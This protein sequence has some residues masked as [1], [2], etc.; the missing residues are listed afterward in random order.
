MVSITAEKVQSR[1][2]II[3]ILFLA[4][5]AGL[6]IGASG[7]AMGV[8][9]NETIESP[10]DT[11]GDGNVEVRSSASPQGPSTVQVTVDIATQGNNT[12]FVFDADG[13]FSTATD[14]GINSSSSSVTVEDGGPNDVDGT[15]DGSVTADLIVDGGSVGFTEGDAFKLGITEGTSVTTSPDTTINSFSIDNT[16]PTI[17]AITTR[18]NG[19]ATG[20]VIAGSNTSASTAD[21]GQI[22]QLV[23]TFEEKIDDS[24]VQTGNFTVTGYTI[25]S[26][27]TAGT[28]NN[29]TIVIDL[30]E[31]G[32]ID[33]GATPEVNYTRGTLADEA[34]NP[35][36]DTVSNPTDGVGP[37]VIRSV[38][39]DANN[40]GTV[41]RVNVTFSENIS[42]STLATG[43][44]SLSGG[45]I[46]S[47]S[48]PDGND[49]AVANLTVSGLTADDTGLTPGLTVTKESVDDLTGNSG[50]AG[51]DQSV[52]S[53]DDAAAAIIS[54]T[55]NDTSGDGDIDQL[56]VIHSEAVDD[57]AST[58]DNTTYALSSGTVDSVLTGTSND[59]KTT[60]TV[61]G[62]SGTDVTPD[63]TLP[64]EKVL[65]DAGNTL[66]ADQT[67]TSTTSG[68]NPVVT[69]IT[70]L[71][72]DSD[73]NVDAANVTTS[74]AINDTT[75]TPGNWA[76]GDN[77]V[78]A[79]DTG[80]T[81]D[82]DALQLRITT[83]ANEATGT[84][85]KEV[86][87][88]PGTAEDV[89]GNSLVAIAAGDVS[90]IDGAPPQVSAFSTAVE[91]KNRIVTTINASES[92]SSIEVAVS[93]A[94]MTTLSSFSA[95]GS[96]PYTHTLTYSPGTTGEFTLTL[97]TAADGAGNDGGDSQTETATLASQS[98]SD[99][100]GSS[101]PS[102]PESLS[103]RVASSRTVIFS[104]AESATISLSGSSFSQ[105][106][107]R[108]TAAA[109][110]FIQASELSQLPSGTSQ[111][112]NQVGNAMSI[113]VPEDMRRN[114]ATVRLSLQTSQ[115]NVDADR[116]R[117]VR[118]NDETGAWTALD[119]QVVS[120]TQSTTLVRA[121]TPGFSLFALTAAEETGSDESTTE[122]PTDT[123]STDGK[124]TAEENLSDTPA[125]AP[126]NEGTSTEADSPGFAPVLTVMTLL[127]VAFLLGRKE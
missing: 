39:G 113:Q 61:S 35:L 40:D 73:G 98:S 93:G 17:N 7:T 47:V 6:V 36:D 100:S 48:N 124:D 96:D 116:L 64:A 123:T 65:D 109:T 92:L 37:R 53:V 16:A 20:T 85:A 81:A 122:S 62:L 105:I 118:Y 66:A 49:D 30:E 45:S 125:P 103:D 19:P 63:V 43:D 26:I 102:Y 58:L 107:I 13:D 110:G 126:N 34:G 4:V 23:V 69:A 11:D 41:D 33:T 91:D 50:P 99:S 57:A 29:D 60:I 8:A 10:A 15:T 111:P 52:T 18:D 78:D 112:P 2:I 77:S 31:S 87:Y 28:G 84:G 70:T 55:T 46:D 76:I 88:S 89:N 106:E 1:N 82:D 101:G 114:S 22:D 38:T 42:D 127:C 115:L 79:I 21:N 80:K 24:T 75:L 94:T 14:Q 86:T 90:E 95:S 74:A 9:S 71:D 67:F 27:T 59:A 44:F 12:T 5:I 56:Q 32:N 97:D 108:P 120:Q 104:D 117:V 83:D 3:F 51:G 25:D 72:R 119:T 121:E 54:A 68:A